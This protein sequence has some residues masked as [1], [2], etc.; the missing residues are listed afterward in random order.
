MDLFEPMRLFLV[1]GIELHR[2]LAGEQPIRGGCGVVHAHQAE[3]RS[4]GGEGAHIRQRGPFGCHMRPHTVLAADTHAR[5]LRKSAQRIPAPQGLRRLQAPH[6]EVALRHLRPRVHHQRRARRAGAR[7]GAARS[8][9][10]ARHP[11]RVPEAV[12]Q[13][14]R[15]LH[16]PRRPGRLRLSRQ[17]QSLRVRLQEHPA[18][19]HTQQTSKQTNILHI[20]FT[21]TTIQ[22]KFTVWIATT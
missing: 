6:S 16:Q 3:R 17:A 15:H 14:V 19:H 4:V 10:V 18:A 8:P 11:L 21:K 13:V 20:Y 5:H 12:R 9:R 2:P 7:R 1:C 22:M